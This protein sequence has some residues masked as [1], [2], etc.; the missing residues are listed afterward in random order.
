MKTLTWLIPFAYV[1]VSCTG[2]SYSGA[3]K[4]D[5]PSCEVAFGKLQGNARSKT[6][7]LNGPINAEIQRGADCKL[8]GILVFP[9]CVPVT[10]IEGRETGYGVL[11]F[12]TTDGSLDI[13]L[14]F[15]DPEDLREDPNPAPFIYWYTF[16]NVHNLPN[17]PATDRGKVDWVEA[18]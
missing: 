9:P 7:A 2:G 1:L 8:T 11:S 6:G 13:E 14:D 12:Q 16:V 10:T 4:D 3:G 17:C 5:G 15:F 18:N